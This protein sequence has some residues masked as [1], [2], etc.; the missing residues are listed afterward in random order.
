MAN[1]MALAEIAMLEGRD[2][3]LSRW[4]EIGQDRIDSFATLTEDSYFIHTDPDRA[5]AES[6]FGD[7]VAHG[8]LTLSFLSAMSYDALPN[9]A[10]KRMQVNYGFDRIRFVAP[11]PAGARIRGRFVLKRCEWDGKEEATLTYGV[12][13][14]IENAERPAVVADW[15]ARI[16]GAFS[17]A[18]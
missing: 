15:V 1:E 10:G 11:V 4:F 13:V 14:E 6:P 7:T 5:R 18:P 2:V 16:W 8:F 12:T 17:D 9:V 3:G